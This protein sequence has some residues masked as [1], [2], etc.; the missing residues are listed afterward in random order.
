[1]LGFVGS[2]Y[3]GEGERE[4]ESIYRELCSIGPTSLEENFTPC[5]II[6]LN[7]SNELEL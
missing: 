2:S 7:E 1:M 5:V 4:R 6:R 3:K